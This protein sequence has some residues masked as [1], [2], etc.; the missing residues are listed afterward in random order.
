MSNQYIIGAGM[1]VCFRHLRPGK[2]LRNTDIRDAHIP[3]G[4]C[5]PGSQ[6]YTSMLAFTTF[7]CKRDRFCTGL[8]QLAHAGKWQNSK[9][10]RPWPPDGKCS[11]LLYWTAKKLL[12][13]PED[14]KA[15]EQYIGLSRHSLWTHQYDDGASLTM[16]ARFFTAFVFK[17]ASRNI[18]QLSEGL[19]NRFQKAF[20]LLIYSNP[21]V[22]FFHFMRHAGDE[23]WYQ[24]R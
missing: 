18:S 7:R 24:C 20:S 16:I 9:T 3:G 23:R 10:A 11:W 12:K 13:C 6:G 17:I 19:T 2:R 21:D 8:A 5:H 4:Q 1:V 15:I 22:P 14:S